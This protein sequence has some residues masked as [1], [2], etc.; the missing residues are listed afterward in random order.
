MGASLSVFLPHARNIVESRK[1]HGLAANL[2]FA[3]DKFSDNLGTS[4]LTSYEHS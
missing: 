1:A 3:H 4:F 2:K